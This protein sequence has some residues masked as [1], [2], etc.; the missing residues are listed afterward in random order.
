MQQKIYVKDSNGKVGIYGFELFAPAGK[1]GVVIFTELPENRA[2]SVTN[3]IERLIKCPCSETP[4]V[5]IDHSPTSY[6][7]VSLSARGEPQWQH[8]RLRSEWADMGIDVPA[9]FTEEA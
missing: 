2:M 5:W 3:N 6:D 7:R 1:P 9:D 8:I 4:G